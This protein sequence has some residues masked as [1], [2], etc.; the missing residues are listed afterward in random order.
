MMRFR[1]GTTDHDG[2]GRMGGSMK[3][4]TMARKDTTKSEPQ[5]KAD[6]KPDAVSPEEAEKARNETMHPSEKRG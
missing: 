3:G 6:P 1:K 4:K 2:D 5:R